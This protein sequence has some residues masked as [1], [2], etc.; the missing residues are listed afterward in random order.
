MFINV[1][2]NTPSY[3]QNIIDLF[4]KNKPI[5]KFNNI[6]I[7]NKKNIIPYFFIGKGSPDIRSLLELH[8]Y[9]KYLETDYIVKL[10][11]ISKNLNSVASKY[12]KEL[13]LEINDKNLNMIKYDKFLNKVEGTLPNKFFDLPNKFEKR[14]NFIPVVEYAKNI[15]KTHLCLKKGS[16]LYKDK[17]YNIEQLSS[18]MK[19]INSKH[20]MIGPNNFT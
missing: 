11:K 9:K 8:Y 7:L 3:F 4:K 16:I 18:I 2:D 19:K 6:E 14:M 1:N 5:Y 20:I 10:S 13:S 17:L 12:I 15:E